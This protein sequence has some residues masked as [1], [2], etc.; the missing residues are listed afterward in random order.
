MQP[1]A[2]ILST[3]VPARHNEQAAADADVAPICPYF[4]AEQGVPE[5][6]DQ[7]VEPTTSEYVPA[8]QLTHV[9]APE[10]EEYLPAPQGA[11]VL[12][13]DAPVA[14]E[15][16]PAPQRAHV[17]SNDAPVAVEYLPGPQSVQAVAQE[18]GENFPTPQGVQVP[19]T[20]PAF[21]AVQFEC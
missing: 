16:L 5:Q 7:E 21:P 18:I 13:N 14:L 10:V 20:G 11:H 6:V 2:P 12:S 15:Y 8:P 19:P 4:P 3:Y 9:L 1:E 17:L